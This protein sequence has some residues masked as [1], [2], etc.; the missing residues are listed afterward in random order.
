MKLIAKSLLAVAA[1]AGAGLAATL[2]ADAA[3]RC[4][5]GYQP[6]FGT[7]LKYGCRPGTYLVAGRC[8]PASSYEGRMQDRI[9]LQNDREQLR[10]AQDWQQYDT[11]LY[12]ARRRAAEDALRRG[13]QARASYY[14]REV[15]NVERH[16]N[17]ERRNESA[18]IQQYMR[19]SVRCSRNR[20]RD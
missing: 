19:D 6:Y 12:W 9:R 15:S 7:C 20:C 16:Y 1:L 17:F 3:P 14:A 11:R 18:F 2:T 5:P 4:G 10:R 8:I 13:D